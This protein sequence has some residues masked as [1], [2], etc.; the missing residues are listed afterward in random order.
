MVGN[1]GF[2]VVTDQVDAGH[3]VHLSR[4]EVFH[5]QERDSVD[6]GQLGESFDGCCPQRRRGL[7]ADQEAA[8]PIYQ[9]DCDDPE[10]YADEDGA[11]GVGDG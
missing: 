2:R 11:E 8:V 9:D 4:P 3:Q 1:S 6:L 5:T 7:F 10:K